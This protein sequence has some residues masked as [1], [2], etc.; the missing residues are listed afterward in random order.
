MSTPRAIAISDVHGCNET[1]GALLDQI[2]FST[3]DHLYIL[4]DLV[5]RGPDSKGVF[6][7]VFELTSAGYQVSCLRGNHE[8]M[9][10]E[11]TEAAEVDVLHWMLNGGDTTL[12]S[13]D[14]DH[15]Q[16]IPDQYI[17]FTRALPYFFEVDGHVLVHAGLNLKRTIPLMD[18]DS[19]LW[20]R[21]WYED[22]EDN[23]AANWLG[24]RIIVHG[25]TPIPKEV[26]VSMFRKLG[27][28][29]VLNIDNGC[30]FAEKRPELGALCAYD[31]TN[32]QL[33]WEFKKD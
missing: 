17:D 16:N 11:S 4:G 20:I 28:K 8:Q 5:D 14:T 15:P 30:V 2:A 27:R 21:N 6:D 33:Y 32:H 26:T 12:A 31:M 7:R 22:F 9:M 24:D 29:P 25:H 3:S 19:M 13:F 18:P 1:F 23:R 10:L